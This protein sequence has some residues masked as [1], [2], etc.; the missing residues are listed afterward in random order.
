MLQDKD[1]NNVLQLILYAYNVIDK[2]ENMIIFYEPRVKSY[3]S[4]YNVLE[5]TFGDTARAFMLFDVDPFHQNNNKISFASVLGPYYEKLIVDN[6][7]N[8]DIFYYV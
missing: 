4:Y 8:N 2:I 5:K 6:K 7:H 1:G 3:E